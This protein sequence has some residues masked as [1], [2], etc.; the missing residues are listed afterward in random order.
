[1]AGTWTLQFPFR[2]SVG[3][4]IGGFLAG[5]RDQRV[6]GATTSSGR[7]LVPPLEYDPD[8]G[9]AT[10]GEVEVSG[11]GVVEH[12]ARVSAPL[13][14]HPTDQ[15]F[16]WVLV[17]L[18]GADTSLLHIANTN[19]SVGDRVQIHW[20]AEREGKITDIEYFEAVK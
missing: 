4:V 2:R 5:L 7:V 13:R 10:T 14:T 9:E 20:R 19:V 12:S 15:P 1:M 11:A 6:V 17:K 16:A 18:D 3:P 8:T